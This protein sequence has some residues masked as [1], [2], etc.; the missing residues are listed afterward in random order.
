MPAVPGA[1]LASNGA[2]E[3]ER[4][5]AV[6]VLPWWAYS[7][8]AVVVAVL[9]GLAIWWLLGEAEGDPKLRIEAIRTALTVGL[10]SGGAF[11]LLI[12]ARRQWLQEQAHVHAERVDAINQAHQERLHAHQAA[13]DAAAHR[14]EPSRRGR[15]PA[16]PMAPAEAGSADREAVH[17]DDRRHAE[18]I[19]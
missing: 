11:A 1:P 6:R 17:D 5:S 14:R 8:R 10:G 7:F 12:N 4:R 15:R 3:A 2:G 16:R 18:E 9:N 13:V 19:P